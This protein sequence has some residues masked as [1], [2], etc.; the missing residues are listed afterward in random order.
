L[1]HFGLFIRDS[2]D[3]FKTITSFR[4]QLGVPF[5]MEIIISMSWAI[6]SVRNDAIRRNV[7]PDIS[8]AKRHFWNDFAQVILIA[9]KA[10]VP[11][12]SRWLE[13]YV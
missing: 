2:V 7:Q 3:P 13:V 4:V 8:N 1:E 11:Y 6:W 5:S 10:Y 9:K 12:I